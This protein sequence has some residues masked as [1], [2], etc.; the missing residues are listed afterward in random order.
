MAINLTRLNIPILMGNGQGLHSGGH[1]AL[2]S[3]WIEAGDYAMASFSL[4]WQIFPPYN[5]QVLS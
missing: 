5:E 1:E 4:T 2:I 3:P